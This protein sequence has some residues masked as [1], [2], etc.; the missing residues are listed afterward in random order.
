[1]D[2]RKR[3]SDDSSQSNFCEV[4]QVPFSDSSRHYASLQHTIK[5]NM[6]RE[7]RLMEKSSKK[8]SRKRRDYQDALK[9]ARQRR[10]VESDDSNDE[11]RESADRYRRKRVFES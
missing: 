10:R 11:Q 8:V 3:R 2:R 1:M 5:R 6:R 7:A 9:R 4:C